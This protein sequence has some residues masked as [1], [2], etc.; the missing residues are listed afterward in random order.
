MNF[1]ISH[2]SVTSHV[3]ISS[4]FYKHNL[5]LLDHL[6]KNFPKLLPCI[7]KTSPENGYP[8]LPKTISLYF[9]TSF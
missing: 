2:Q 5:I 4:I 8:C 3:F 9:A 6:H 7:L 1:P